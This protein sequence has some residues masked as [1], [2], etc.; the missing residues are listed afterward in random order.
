MGTPQVVWIVLAAIGVTLHMV[1][2]GE[3]TTYNFVAS[4]I[5]TAISAGILYWGG[6]FAAH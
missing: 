1:K 5:A 3:R 6:F 2:H 4:V